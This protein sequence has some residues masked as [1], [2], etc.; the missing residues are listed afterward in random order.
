MKLFRTIILFGGNLGDV[1]ATFEQVKLKLR[2]CASGDITVSKIYI[3]EPWGFESEHVFYNMCASFNT[4]YTPEALL[5]FLLKTENE[6]GR[7]RDLGAKGYTSRSIDLDILFYEN[8]I[9]HTNDL[10]IPHPRMPFRRFTLVPL[11]EIAS[12]HVHPETGQ[13]VRQML[14]E[15]TDESQIRLLESA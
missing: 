10:D 7:T 6:L 2:V 12:T 15:C 8:F 3:S 4:G 14:E 9:L 5:E 11:N 1:P 13:T